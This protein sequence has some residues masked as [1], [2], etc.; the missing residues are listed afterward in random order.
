MKRSLIILSFIAFSIAGAGA[1]R[2]NF[3]AVCE[4]GQTL[5]YIITSS[6]EPYAVKVTYPQYYN[7][8]MYLGNVTYYHN[9]IN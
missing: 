3:S 7:Y 6:V 4:S 2:Y 9:H 5:Y 1:E 8:G